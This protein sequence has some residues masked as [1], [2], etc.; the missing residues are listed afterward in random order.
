MK[1]RKRVG[2][3]TGEHIVTSLCGAEVDRAGT[4]VNPNVALLACPYGTEATGEPR[5]G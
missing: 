3:T 5:R 4:E 2:L 1:G